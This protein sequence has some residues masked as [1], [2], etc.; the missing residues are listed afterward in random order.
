MGIVKKVNK[1][2]LNDLLLINFIIGL[3]IINV[4]PIVI[5]KIS[6][7]PFITTFLNL[8]LIFKTINIVVAISEIFLFVGITI[9][10]L[11]KSFSIKLIMIINILIS[12]VMELIRYLS[13]YNPANLIYIV[14]A[15]LISIITTIVYRTVRK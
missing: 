2:K 10:F 15:V 3:F 5:G 1:I 13:R 4:F 14:L 12:F 8:S 11:K 9:L 7:Y 6:D